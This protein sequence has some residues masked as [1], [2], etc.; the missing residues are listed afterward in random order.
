METIKLPNGMWSYDPESPLGPAGGFGEV[1]AGFSDDGKEVAVKRIKREVADAAHRELRI[2]QELIGR[3]FSHV[4]PFHDAGRDE[5]SGCYFIVMARASTSLQASLSKSEPYED[6]S[7]SSVLLDIARGLAE[8]PEIT[9]RDL[10]PANVLLHEGRW[11]VADFGIARF[12]EE[13]TSLNTL[14]GCLSPQYA[15]PEQWQLGRSTTATDVYALG[16]IAVTLVLGH[17]PFQGPEEHDYKRQH[18]TEEP[19]ALEGR[20]PRLRSLIFSMLRKPPES[21]PA[22]DRVLLLL[23]ELAAAKSMHSP[24]LVA[25]AE[26]GASEADRTAADE[27]K[28][29]KE[30][31]DA[32]RRASLAKG[33]L[34]TLKQLTEQLMESVSRRPIHITDRMA[35]VIGSMGLGGPSDW[36]FVNSVGKQIAETKT[37]Q[38][39]KAHA[40]E[41]DVLVEIN[42]RTGRIWSAI[43]WHWLRHYHRTRAHVSGIR[44]EVSKLAMGHAADGIHDHYRGV[45]ADAFHAEY[46]KFDSG[47]DGSLL[48]GK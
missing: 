20:D 14:R 11:K 28:A 13:A 25:L 36:V 42:P 5:D 23:T 46:A 44:R 27:A 40:L 29:K 19:P 33:G 43:K 10:K 4:V 24:G 48:T 41:A 18:L 17:P 30:Q 2:V 32:E 7:T 45:D 15:A 9:H 47:I 8:V 37:L 22:L 39:L 35:K 21:R 31:A 1:F 26:A 12:V 6:D 38:K 3:P 16:C 34:Q